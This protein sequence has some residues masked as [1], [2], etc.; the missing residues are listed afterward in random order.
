[1]KNPDY[2][3]S[4]MNDGFKRCWAC[5]MRKNAVLKCWITAK[6]SIPFVVAMSTY[7]CLK[8]GAVFAI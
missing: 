5:V 4:K 6:Y 3:Y 2:A 7:L 1:M 8:T